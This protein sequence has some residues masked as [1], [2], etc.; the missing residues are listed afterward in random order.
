MPSASFL[1][2]ILYPPSLRIFPL[3]RNKDRALAGMSHPPVP[4]LALHLGCFAFPS[5]YSVLLQAIFSAF[6]ASFGSFVI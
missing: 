3:K 1:L 6:F 2:I 4:D 5:I